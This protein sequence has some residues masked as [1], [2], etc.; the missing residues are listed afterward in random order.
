MRDEIRSARP[1]TVPGAGRSS[2]TPH[3]RRRDR[4][5][6]TDRS[7]SID[8]RARYATLASLPLPPRSS[9]AINATIAASS[10]VATPSSCMT[11]AGIQSPRD[12]AA[13]VSG[14]GA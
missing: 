8:A 9:A 13:G 6:R 4:C 14:E 5:R 12:P 2:I 3:D 11:V 1:V 7:E 10:S